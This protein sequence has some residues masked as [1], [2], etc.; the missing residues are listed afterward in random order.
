MRK[1]PVFTFMNKM[2]RPALEP[3]QLLDEVEKEFEPPTYPVNWP[4]GSETG[5]DVD[6][7]TYPVNWP[8]GCETGEEFDL[9]TYPVNWPIGS[10]DKCPAHLA[11]T[12]R[13]IYF[14]S[15]FHLDA[16]LS[17][18]IFNMEAR[19]NAFFAVPSTGPSLR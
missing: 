13:N 1:L 11:I 17:M 15:H 6:L 4:I 18:D 7:P 14:M 2:D 10:G 19:T 3:L 12:S 16:H 9:P 5:G 8:I